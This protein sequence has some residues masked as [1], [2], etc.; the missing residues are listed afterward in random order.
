M[1][2]AAAAASAAEAQF[3]LRMLVLCL[4]SSTW[5]FLAIG[6]A[7]LMPL[8]AAAPTPDGLGFSPEALGMALVPNALG[9]KKTFFFSVPS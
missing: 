6:V 2:T 4:C 5:M 9:E 1:A 3:R 8:F 7:E